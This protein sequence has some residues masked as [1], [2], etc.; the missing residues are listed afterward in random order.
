MINFDP[1]PLK[2][3]IN[4]SYLKVK[5]FREEFEN[6]KSELSKLLS[7]INDKESEEHNKNYVRDF[8]INTFYFVKKVNTKGKTDLAIHLDKSPSSKVG[9][10]IEAKSPSNKSDMITTLNLNFKALHEVI[11]YYLQERIDFK[12]DE[13]KHIIITNA[14]EWFIF[15]AEVFEKLFYKGSLKKEYEKWKT[16]QKVS[17]NNDFFYNLIK[18]YLN[19]ENFGIEGIQFNLNDYKKKL[20]KDEKTLIPLFKVFSPP[21]L[22]K[23]PFANDS[24]T[25]NKEFY[26][27]LMHIIGL[28]EHKEG[29]KKIIRRKNEKDRDNGSLLENTIRILKSEDSLGNLANPEHFGESEDEKL[30]NLALELNITWMN[31]ILFL[32]LLEAQLVNFNNGK[33]EFKFLDPKVIIEYDDLYELFHEVLA[34]K[35]NERSKDIIDK[36]KNIPYLNSSLFDI[37][38]LE[39]KTIRISNLKD[40]FEL[41]LY[42]KTVFPKD[43]KKKEKLPALEYLLKFLDAYDFASESGEEIQ[44]ESKTIINASVL[45]LIFE[46]INGYK[47]GSFYTPGFITMY[48]ARETLR[49]AV[50]QKFNEAKGTGYKDY[51]DLRKDIDTSSAGREEANKIVNSLK[52]CDPAVGSGHFLVSCLNEL[53]AIKA[54]LRILSD[55]QGRQVRDFSFIIENDELVI[56]DEVSDELFT[57]KLNPGGKPVTRIQELQETLFHEKETII[58]NCLFGVDLNPNSV[59]ICRLRLWIELLKNSYYTEESKYTELETLPNIDIN[60]KQGNSLISRFDIKQDMFSH[61]DMQT[62]EVYKLNVQLYKNEHDKSKRKALKES[63]EKTK[64]RFKGIAVEPLKKERDQ[65]EKFTEQLYEL[66]KEDMFKDELSKTEKEK[67]EKKR[68]EK[69]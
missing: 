45:G 50:V 5:P 11:L 62:L 3:S 35:V 2:K 28:E 16:N 22:L 56:T 64:Q 17:H 29:S 21:E 10:I 51:D 54:D 12:N 31:R 36:F 57:Y 32:K 24:N 42:N 6:F 48:M 69:H 44:E 30:F 25:L 49:R 47:E 68:K 46:K 4:K 61:G 33:N 39:R 1:I 41:K 60:I 19:N 37:S 34:K 27:E 55:R 59:N 38:E 43:I 58:E 9:V 8:L 14:Y 52:I 15:K 67:I 13:I 63:I 66:N 26:L 7:L 23:E 20:A 18:E 53:I 65:I 40:R